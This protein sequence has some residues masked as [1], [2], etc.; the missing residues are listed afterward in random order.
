MSIAKYDNLVRARISGLP[1]PPTV[2]LEMEFFKGALGGFERVHTDLESILRVIQETA[3]AMLDTHLLRIN[4][5][6]QSLHWRP[7]ARAEVARLLATVAPAGAALAVRSAALG[8]DLGG[9]SFAGIYRTELNVPA[10]PD[11]VLVS[12]F[13]VWVSYFSLT[14]I[15]QRLM[16][17]TLCDGQRMSVML[18]AMV[19]AV[20]AGVLFTRAPEGGG[21]MQLEF[22]A[23]L[24][25][26]LVGGSAPAR[27]VG[28]ADVSSL[29][30]GPRVACQAAFGVAR[31]LVASRGED[32]DIEWAFDGDRVWLLQVR[33]IT[34]GRPQPARRHSDLP[35]FEMADLFTADERQ[36]QHLRPLPE[37]AEYFRSKR[38]PLFEL[39]RALGVS[40]GDSTLVVL[41]QGGWREPDNQRKLSER[42]GSGSV[43]LDCEDEIRQQ[44]M[45]TTQLTSRITA[46]V[47]SGE[48]TLSMLVRQFVRGDAGLISRAAGHH[49]VMCEYS[50]A[51][52][53]AINR[54]I[55]DTE[56]FSVPSSEAARVL[57]VRLCHTIVAATR[58]AHAQF[59]SVQ[60]EWV[61]DGEH[62]YLIDFS[63]ISSDGLRAETVG[64]YKVISTGVAAGPV[65]VVEDSSDLVDI[66][67]GPA[68][69]VSGVPEELSVW[70][71]LRALIARARNFES[72]PV[73]VVSRPYAALASLLPHVCGFVF[74]S[75]AL[76]CHL[77]IQ[78]REHRIPAIAGA[79][80]FRSTATQTSTAFSTRMGGR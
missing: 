37:F 25:D 45:P 49:S 27:L 44:V 31:D 29:E 63:P 51:G 2:L 15:T 57:P 39:G 65:M 7:E 48:A 33:P 71:S 53:M 13:Q 43:V 34:T 11:A 21:G 9:R 47:A 5:L 73:V 72:P 14:A 10:D 74:E 62:L 70:S 68:F 8:E 40:I 36:L 30:D 18:Q 22:V 6:L 66:S 78:L 56:V 3:G 38:R 1:V 61:K 41:N 64:E 19:Q 75:A 80:V 69:S 59:G 58:A 16:A 20:Y 4:Q 24:G 28:E 42:F 76:L 55:A 54:G 77:A 67:V 79:Q 12:I 50:S 52:L 35:V 60:L 46:I 17:K 26:E 23:G 32:L